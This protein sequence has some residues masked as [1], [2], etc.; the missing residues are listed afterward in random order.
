MYGQEGRRVDYGAYSCAKIITSNQP[1]SGDC[2]GCPFKAEH[3]N[4]REFIA[5]SIGASSAGEA[6]EVLELASRGHYQ[7]AC[8]RYYEIKH[9]GKGIKGG[10]PMIHPS[11]YFTSSVAESAQ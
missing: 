9:G 8:T 4:T 10:E 11:V 6:Q 2:H 5:A 1:G 7:V 3:G